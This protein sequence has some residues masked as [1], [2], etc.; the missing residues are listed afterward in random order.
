MDKQKSRIANQQGTD[1]KR[2][3][4]ETVV[5]VAVLVL[6]LKTFVAEAFVIPTGS[7]AT[8]LLGAQKMVKCPQC[9]YEFAVNCSSERETRPGREPDLVVRCTC[10]NCRYQIDFQHEH[11]KPSCASGDRLVVGK[12][13]YDLHLNRV[14]R[15]D[16]VVFKYPKAPQEHYEAMNYIKRLIGKPGET[17]AI[18]QGDLYV[19]PGSEKEREQPLTY[20]RHPRPSRPEELWQKKYMYEDDAEA[21]DLFRQG[22]FQII[23]KSPAK[24]LALRR[25]VYDNAHPAKDLVESKFPPR[26]APEADRDTGTAAAG[27]LLDYL[28]R[29]KLAEEEAAWVSDT[30]HGFRH[31]ARQGPLAWL[32]YR[33]LIL[34]RGPEKRLADTARSE[35]KPELI[36]DFMGYDSWKSLRVLHSTPSPNW[37]GD[38]I[39][40]CEVNL[41]P[42]D[43]QALQGQLVLELS[44]GVDRFQARWEMPSGQCS[45]VRVTG[46]K[47]EQLESKPTALKPGGNHRLRFAN[48][49]ARLI[50]WVD[51]SLPFGEGVAY[52]APQESGPFANDLQPV[53]IGAHGLALRVDQLKLWRDTYYTLSP[54]GSDATLAPSDWSDPEKWQPLRKLP[55]ETF[56]VQPGHY[57]CLGD[58]S[59]E[60][61]DSRSWG[62]VPERL[63]LGRA[64]LVYYPFRRIGPIE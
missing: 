10:P 53:S 5:I 37:V 45:L 6:L 13:L 29:R 47:E 33:H 40:E 1:G 9:G 51:R 62:V 30:A 17:L 57:L 3:I 39:L 2:E 41:S 32:R 14:E 43:G 35:I 56:Y 23:R 7:M 4:I 50:V 61:A 16:V 59:P 11:P 64:L 46:S 52:R 44:K 49:D 8:T 48:V 54:S 27:D 15:Q 63:L 20:P 31:A 60:S 12:F 25:L 55:V 24:V 21:L 19:Y 38:L 26:W 34:E 42:A 22:K 58:N 36:T 28:R 18:H